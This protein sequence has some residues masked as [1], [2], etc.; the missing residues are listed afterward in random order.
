MVA[1]S[2]LE[3]LN[4]A[5]RAGGDGAVIDVHSDDYEVLVLGNKFIEHGLVYSRLIKAQGEEN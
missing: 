5:H 3:V 2:C 1:Q 4:E